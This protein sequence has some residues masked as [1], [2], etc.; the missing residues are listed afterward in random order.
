MKK[1]IITATL[2]LFSF[3]SSAFAEMTPKEMQQY[4]KQK[5]EELAVIQ[6]TPHEEKEGEIF[7]RNVVELC[8]R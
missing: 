1:F 6:K 4:C 5:N 7:L 2:I 3:S 8:K